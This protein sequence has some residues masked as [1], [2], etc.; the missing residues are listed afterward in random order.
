MNV[1]LPILS[2]RGRPINLIAFRHGLELCGLQLSDVEFESATL[3]LRRAEGRKTS[4]HSLLGDEP[5]ALRALRREAE[6]P[7]VFVSER[8]APFTVG[9]FAKL[10]EGAG[11]EAGMPFK[12]LHH[13][14][15]HDFEP[16]TF[17]RG[18]SLAKQNYVI[19][20]PQ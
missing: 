16:R 2:R 9:G 15:G 7:F 1:F 10:I 4:T 5:R 12:V 14:T 19:G 20:L 8:S 11:V 17:E 3:H 6:A 18:V 13:S